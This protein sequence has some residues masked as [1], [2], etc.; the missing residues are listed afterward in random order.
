MQKSGRIQVIAFQSP[1]YSE[2]TLKKSASM[3]LKKSASLDLNRS[4]SREVINLSESNVVQ[5]KY[6]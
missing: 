3:D 2:P 1:D 4:A 5:P 6:S